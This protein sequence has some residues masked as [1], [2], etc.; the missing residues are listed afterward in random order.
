MIMQPTK[1]KDTNV[2]WSKGYQTYSLKNY[3][4]IYETGVHLIPQLQTNSYFLFQFLVAC[5]A[6]SITKI[7]GHQNRFWPSM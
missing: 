7:I 5:L 1:Y 2:C 3:L 6:D 4:K